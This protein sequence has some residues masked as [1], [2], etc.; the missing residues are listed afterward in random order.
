MRHDSDL[1]IPVKIIKKKKKITNIII[2]RHFMQD[3]YWKTFIS[4]EIDGDL[5]I[6]IVI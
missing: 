1:K 2:S 3:N 6:T 5:G 4:K